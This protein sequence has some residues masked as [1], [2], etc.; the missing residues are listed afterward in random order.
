[1]SVT[2]GD[3]LTWPTADK[4]RLLGRLRTA[5]WEDMARPEQLQPDTDWRIWYLMGGRG[6]GKSRTGAETFCSWIHEHPAGEWAI[7]APTFADAR[8][9][10]VESASSGILPI[11]GPAVQNW[12]RSLGEILLV[13]GSKIYLDGA[14]DGALRI[15]GKNLRGAWC[16]ECGL[17]NQWDRAWNESLAF[18]VRHAPARIVATGT[19]KMGHG[20]VK[21]LVE[22]PLIPK[23]Q[24]RTSDNVQNLNPSAVRE[25]YTKYG[26]TRLGSQELDGEWLEAIEGDMLKRAWWKYF[27]PKLL[28][29]GIQV[30]RL[31]KFQMIL[32]SVDTPLKDKETSDFVALQAWGVIGG[33]RYL[34]DSRKDRLSYDQAKRAIMEMAATM[35]RTFKHCQHACLIENAG[36]GVELVQELKRSM[37]GVYKISVGAEG[38]KTMRALSASADLETGNCFL[39]GWALPELTGPDP[40]RTPAWVIDFIDECALFDNGPNDDQVDAWSQAMNWLRSRAPSPLRT[41]SALRSIRTR[42]PFIGTTRRG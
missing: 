3:A 19:P 13:D 20:L 12:N 5:L 36:Y 38:N 4:I 37:G 14:D 8:D 17:W 25:L 24:M 30:D 16:D 21:L 10:C 2:L 40:G 15:Q 39:P 18:A 31:P 41:A 35:R 28:T 9:T 34:L 11:L 33:D 32:L 23:S 42:N 29:K 7:V 26:G 6:S 22:D 1:M 27:D